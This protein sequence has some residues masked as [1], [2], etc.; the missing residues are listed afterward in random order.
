MHPAPPTSD[1]DD[2]PARHPHPSQ[3]VTPPSPSCSPP[4]LPQVSP[5][6]H[7]PCLSCPQKWPPCLKFPSN[8]LDPFST[9][10]PV[11]P[12]RVT[13]PISAYNPSMEP[14]ILRTALPPP[15]GHPVTPPQQ[16]PLRA[17]LLNPES[18]RDCVR[19]ALRQFQ[20]SVTLWG[21][22]FTGPVLTPSLRLNDNTS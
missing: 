22:I 18:G 1:I 2:L 9:Q 7:P 14:P 5:H 6:R 19:L 4:P 11:P 8:H 3:A 13:C 15:Q 12:F 17:S 20:A 21:P 10:P 16:P